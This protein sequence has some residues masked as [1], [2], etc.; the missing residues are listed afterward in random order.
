MSF[1]DIVL[2]FFQ[3]IIGKLRQLFRW[4]HQVLQRVVFVYQ[5]KDHI[6]SSNKLQAGIWKRFAA[7]ELSKLKVYT[8][9]W[10]IDVST[11]PFSWNENDNLSS[12]ESLIYAAVNERQKAIKP[13]YSSLQMNEM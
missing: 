8:Y 4:I 5:K 12:T 6:T 13:I 10:I 2:I 3:G 1:Y 7:I 9:Y 11:N